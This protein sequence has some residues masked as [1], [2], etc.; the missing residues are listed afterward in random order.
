MKTD[1]LVNTPQPP[2]PDPKLETRLELNQFNAIAQLLRCDPS[3]NANI[4]ALAVLVHGTS[5]AEAARAV[6]V[7]RSSVCDAV[8]RIKTAHK[9]ILST[10]LP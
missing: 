1:K 9:I 6:G 2:A 3:S 10:F 8:T 7:S 4:A 5:Q